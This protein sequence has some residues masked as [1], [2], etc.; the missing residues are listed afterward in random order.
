MG[1][2]QAQGA[3]KAVCFLGLAAFMGG[4]SSNG[5]AHAHPDAMADSG[6]GAFPE[7]AVEAVQIFLPDGAWNFRCNDP[8]AASCPILT[9][10]YYVNGTQGKCLE[11]QGCEATGNT[12]A[13]LADCESQCAERLFCTCS[14][15]GT[16]D[17]GGL[18]ASCPAPELFPG[19]TDKA[20]GL[21][22]PYPGLECSLSTTLL[23]DCRCVSGVDQSEATWRCGIVDRG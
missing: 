17:N 23:W 8:I 22:C 20:S 7:T 5:L 3:L 18:C 10:R 2:M 16:C 15:G 13:T 19:E 11:M 14:V 6:G 4:C 9:V 1:R 12:F 21:P